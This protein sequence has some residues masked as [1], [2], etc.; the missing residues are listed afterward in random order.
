MNK[1]P[2]DIVFE[3]LTYSGHGTMRKGYVR[4]DGTIHPCKFIFKIPQNLLG[5]Q[6]K[7]KLYDKVILQIHNT[8]KYFEISVLPSNI[9]GQLKYQI[10]I[11]ND[12]YKY[13]NRTDEFTWHIQMCPTR[14]II[15]KKYIWQN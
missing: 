14:E 2:L 11:W 10:D 15:Y 8:T 13:L 3:I 1:L 9:R 7:E 12:P 4:D 5:L 6:L